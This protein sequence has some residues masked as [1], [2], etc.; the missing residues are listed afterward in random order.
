MCAK[1]WVSMHNTQY[2]NEYDNNYDQVTNLPH[3]AC[4]TSEP[5]PSTEN[6]ICNQFHEQINKLKK[7]YA[8]D[9][10]ADM[11]K[12]D[13]DLKHFL[14]APATEALL[15]P[16]PEMRFVVYNIK[17]VMFFFFQGR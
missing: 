3:N 6:E 4:Q 12:I 15:I 10:Q 8:L 1:K 11:D 13:K 7:K 16:T 17:V 14:K 5:P 2:V 9:P